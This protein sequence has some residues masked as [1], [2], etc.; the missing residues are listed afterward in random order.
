M[1]IMPEFGSFCVCAVCMFDMLVKSELVLV[2]QI[3]TKSN[4]NM[5]RDK[6]VTKFC[7]S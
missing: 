7:Q 3:Y 2:E 1:F 4:V 5:V 6:Y